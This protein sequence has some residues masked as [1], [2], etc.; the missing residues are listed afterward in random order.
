LDI[1]ERIH[2]SEIRARN[3]IKFDVV[4]LI[5]AVVFYF[6]GPLW[7][8]KLF[9]GLTIFFLAQTILEYWNARRLKKSKITS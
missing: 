9:A 6:L 2:Q 5:V 4:L 3:G 7:L 1:E 8:A